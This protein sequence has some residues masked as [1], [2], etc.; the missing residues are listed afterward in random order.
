M[1]A[2]PEGQV[3]Q[4]LLLASEKDSRE[5]LVA[6]QSLTGADGLVATCLQAIVHSAYTKKYL[7]LNAWQQLYCVLLAEGASTGGTEIW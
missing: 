6:A 3:L 5:L 1:A 7:V 4:T 2:T